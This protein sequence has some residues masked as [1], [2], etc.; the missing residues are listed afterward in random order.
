ME[1][2]YP[3]RFKPILKERIWGGDK[4]K[5]YLN[6]DLGELKKVGESWE[7][8]ALEGNETVVDN[9]SLKGKTIRELISDYDEKLLG[10]RPLML[11]GKSFPL[12]IKFIDANDDLSIQ[13]HPN[14]FVAMQRNNSFGKT[15]MWYVMQADKEAK[16]I[17]GFVTDISKPIFWDAIESGNL[18]M[19]VN[20]QT[21]NQ[22]DA[23]FIPAGRIHA[24]G[25]GCVVAEI[26]QSS[27]ITYRVFDYNRKDTDGN[28]RELHINEAIDVIDYSKP[29]KLKSEYLLR[30]NESNELIHSDYF[31]T[32]ILHIQGE[33]RRTYTKLSSFKIFMMVEGN[34]VL[35]N[36]N[37]E[38]KLTIGDT[39]LVPAEIEAV[40]FKAQNAKILEVFI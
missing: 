18:L 39:I 3:L 14:D 1:K 2:L 30:E 5:T 27:D 32:N 34:A 6:K 29:D 9:G 22:G 19:I 17:N 15:E 11:F 25:K 35:E 4:L 38:Y 10:K 12:L 8:S 21:V 20:Q 23:Y 26:Q 16:I 24:L 36:Q 7:I 31:K 13:V 33:I 40:C 28:M 37:N